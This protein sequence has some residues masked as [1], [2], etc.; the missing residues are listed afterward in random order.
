MCLLAQYYLFKGR[1]LEGH[2]HTSSATRFAVTM[3]LHQ[4]NSRIFQKGLPAKQPRSVMGVQRWQ[5]S[6]SIELGEAINVWWYVFNIL[7]GIS[8]ALK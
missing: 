2:F 8:N 7:L 4:L 3:G 6:D 5:P 1:L